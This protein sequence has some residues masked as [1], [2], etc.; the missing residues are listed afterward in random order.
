[1]RVKPTKLSKLLLD[2]SNVGCLGQLEVCVIIAIGAHGLVHA[3]QIDAMQIDALWHR[4][5]DL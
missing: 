5:G 4:R 3:M 1:V 2:L